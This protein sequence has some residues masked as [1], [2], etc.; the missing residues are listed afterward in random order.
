M[1][2]HLSSTQIPWESLSSLRPWAAPHVSVCV[3]TC[4]CLQL[5]VIPLQDVTRHPASLPSQPLFKKFTQ[6]RWAVP[7]Q[8]LEEIITTVGIRLPEFSELYDCFREV[9]RCWAG[10]WA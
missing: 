4:A 3:S 10:D 1:N 6:T 7:E 9:S 2:S 8:T 5:A